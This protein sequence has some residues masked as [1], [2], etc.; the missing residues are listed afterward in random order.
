[1]YFFAGHRMKVSC[2]K[3]LLLNYKATLKRNHS[4]QV[5]V[6]NLLAT[7]TLLNWYLFAMRELQDYA[8]NSVVFIFN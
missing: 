5:W 2:Q 3:W 4:Q 7:F 1:M 6:E 8:F